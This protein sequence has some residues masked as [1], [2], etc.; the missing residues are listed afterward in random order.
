MPRTT[1]MFASNFSR[2]VNSSTWVLLPMLAVFVT[3]FLITRYIVQRYA[4]R[5]LPKEPP[6]PWGLPVFGYLM[7]LK[8]SS[9]LKLTKLG[10]KF[11]SVYQIFLGSKRVV[12]VSDPKLVRKAFKQSIFSGRPDTSLTRLMEG[13]GIINSGGKLWLEQRAFL[14]SVL[15]EFGARNMGPNSSSLEMN[16]Q[17][18]VAE[19]LASLYATKESKVYIRPVIARAVSNVV[20]TMLMSVTFNE[21]DQGFKRLLYLIEDGFKHL[22]VAAPVNFMP[23]L[24]HLPIVRS[25]YKK[26]QSNKKETDAYFAHVAR[27][28]KETLDP[29]NIRD[30]VDSFFVK[31][32]EARRQ[33]K[34]T[35]FSDQQLHQVMGDVF[36]AGLETVTSTLEWSVVFL[37]RHKA[38]QR[39]FQQEIDEVIGSERRPELSDMPHMPYAE[40]F[41]LEV[42]RRANVIPLGNSH[43]TLQD[44]QL[45]GYFIPEGTHILPN[46]WAIHMDPNLW[47][48]PEDFRPERFLV[49]GAVVKPQH[50]MPFS[51]GRRMCVGDVLTKMEVFLFLTGILQHFDLE[52]PCDED[53]PNLDAENHVS[54]S[55]KPFNVCAFQRE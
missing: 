37:V 30:F 13:Y 46:L 25:A 39:R 24:R 26:I 10:K 52:V 49:D 29:E 7:F 6:G 27:R 1:A 16:I 53:L 42:L 2:Y 23:S 33:N 48:S 32:A 43:A 12:V 18:Q 9:H 14:H 35:F 11:G 17:N 50:F 22:T 38:V 34:D 4:T 21:S 19:L 45:G 40:A 31:Q 20:G 51:V 28:H 5:N 41:Y 44:T 36:S 15:R 3:V 8:R 55:A 54:L 47:D